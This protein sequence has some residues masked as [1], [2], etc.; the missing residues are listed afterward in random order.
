MAG[1]R[2]ALEPLLAMLPRVTHGGCA[3]PDGAL[4]RVP[5]ASVDL[6]EETYYCATVANITVSVPDTV[7]DAARV[8]AA[9]ARTSVSALVR[10]YLIRIAAQGSEF[11]RLVDMQEDILDR[12]QA[13]ASGISASQRMTRDA[14][15]D[16]DALR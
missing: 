14:L 10:E 5:F 7:Y 13:S 8:K 9:E 16:R 4:H 3:R 11:R 15:H 1:S 12:I 2:R 6:R